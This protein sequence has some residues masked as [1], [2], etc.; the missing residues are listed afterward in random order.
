VTLEVRAGDILG[1]IGPI[2][3]ARLT[4][5]R[6]W[7]DGQDKARVQ[8]QRIAGLG[9]YPTKVSLLAGPR[10]PYSLLWERAGVRPEPARRH[11]RAR[12]VRRCSKSWYGTG[13]WSSSSSAAISSS[14]GLW[15]L[16]A[17]A[18]LRDHGVAAI[19]G[20]VFETSET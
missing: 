20:G 19:M 9:G 15:P 17:L 12:R 3:V 2:N 5:A 10:A 11:S 6:S 16:S 18:A 7:L 4:V 13:G 8:A 1:L 14:K